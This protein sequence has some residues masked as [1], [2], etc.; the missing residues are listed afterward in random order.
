MIAS[1]MF[2]L[3]MLTTPPTPTHYVTDNASAL[4]ASTDAAIE[5][6]LSDFDR[7][8]GNQVIVWI[9]DT[10]GDTPLE[11][12]T[13]Q[14]A[15]AWKIGH[16]AK[17][18]GAVLFLFM[19][20]HKIRIEVGYGLESKLT[21]AQSATIINDTI[22]PAMHDGDVDGAVQNGVNAMLGVIDPSYTAPSATSTPSDEDDGDGPGEVIAALVIGGIF[23]LLI[24]CV[25]VTI[26]RRGKKHGDWLDLFLMSS[27]MGPSNWSMM[28][29]GGGFGG[30]GG[31]FSAGGGG[32]GGGGAS[33]GW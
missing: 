11:E 32:F 2:A 28:H 5:S 15:E 21:D 25:I 6:E 33:G 14:A 22:H 7:K 12:W 23:L 17:Q 10:T 31:G 1:L 9:G 18:N 13:S 16:K 8:T 4:S 24:V 27:S 19:R 30:G 3:A 29:G 20:D 26:A